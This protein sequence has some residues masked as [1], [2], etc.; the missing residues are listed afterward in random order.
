MLVGVTRELR[1]VGAGIAPN[2]LARAAAVARLDTLGDVLH[3]AL[4]QQPAW[5][6]V[7]VVVQDE[8]TH[9]VVIAAQ[10]PAYLVLDTT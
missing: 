6:V 8:Y 7:D 10:P 1:P 9:D 2:T 5:Q 3:L 4:A